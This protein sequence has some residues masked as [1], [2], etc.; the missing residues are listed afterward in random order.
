MALQWH[1]MR[2]TTNE[3]GEAGGRALRLTRGAGDSPRQ[4]RGTD[5]L[6]GRSLLARRTLR[7]RLSDESSTDPSVRKVVRFVKS[8]RGE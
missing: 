7:I 2:V 1:G 8:D 4:I 5:Y 6:N 3:T